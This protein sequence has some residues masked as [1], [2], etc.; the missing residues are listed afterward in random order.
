MSNRPQTSELGHYRILTPQNNRYPLVL[1]ALLGQPNEVQKLH[2]RSATDQV[3]LPNARYL[4]VA[5][6]HE[7]SPSEQAATEAFLIDFLQSWQQTYPEL[8]LTIIA[9]LAEGVDT[10][11]HHAALTT[12]T[13]SVGVLPTPINRAP[14]RHSL[15]LINAILTTPTPGNAVVSEYPPVATESTYD[16]TLVAHNRIVAWSAAWLL[17]SHYHTYRSA[18]TQTIR[19]A[20][21]ARRPVLAHQSSIPTGLEDASRA[22]QINTVSSSEE[23]LT[24]LNQPFYDLIKQ[25]EQDAT[26]AELICGL[27]ATR[28]LSLALQEGIQ[29]PWLARSVLSQLDGYNDSN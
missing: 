7:V 20:L 29:H 6:H 10:I 11:A 22:L 9:G 2:V 21:L 3:L 14:S 4:G 28:N 25:A 24:Q 17:I 16:R 18:T 23:L 27:T 26:L 12:G 13:P 8:C 19:Y 15:E 1:K 5:G